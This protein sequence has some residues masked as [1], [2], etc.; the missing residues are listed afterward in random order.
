V[1]HEPSIALAFTPEPWVETLH[2]HLADHGGARVRQLVMDPS[3][4][5][6]DEYE[7]LV[8][9]ARWPALTAGLVR[10]LH[11]RGRA[12][13]GVASRDEP[14][15][16]DVLVAIEVDRV[17]ISDAPPEEFLEALLAIAPSSPPHDRATIEE[18]GAAAVPNVV[19]SGAAGTGSTE[20]AIAFA[21][22]AARTRAVALIDAD[23]V[24]PSLA[25]RLSLPIEPNL[26]TAIEAVEHTPGAIEAQYADLHPVRNGLRVVGGLPGAHNWKQVRPSEVERVVRAVSRD[27]SLVVIDAAA[28]LDD[29]GPSGR[30]RYALT[31][32]LVAGADELIAVGHGSPVG[33]TRLVTWLADAHQLN[34]SA[35]VHVV[36]NRVPADAF[37]RR[38][39][40]VEFERCY[41]PASLTLAPDDPKVAVAAWAGRFVE[42]GAFV[43][44]IERLVVEVTGLPARASRRQRRSSGVVGAVHA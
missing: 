18:P 41:Q 4:A 42:R 16:V 17:V 28:P 31:R 38:E 37:R 5:I 36:L 1:R 24:A 32:A 26:R 2:R 43:R 6:D 7:V 14:G 23:E 3:L 8:A 10:A 20:V 9:S 34:T 19:V 22:I 13:L 44:A 11:E 29:V 27:C 35:A 33:L 40:A 15:G 39:L 12:V 21:A 30:G 25:Q